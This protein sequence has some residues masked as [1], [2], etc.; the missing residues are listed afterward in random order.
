MRDIVIERHKALIEIWR[1][2]FNRVPNIY[3]HM[4]TSPAPRFFVSATTAALQCSKLQRGILKNNNPQR[5]ELYSEI[6]KRFN[7][8][9][10]QG[11]NRPAISLYEDIVFEPA[12]SFYLE[13]ATIKT[14][15]EKSQRYEY[16]R[17][18]NRRP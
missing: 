3:K 1:R 13:E 18:R 8:L 6:L 10:R 2:D 9:R 12:P 15:I 5:I 11:D 4:A 17:N 16:N 14:I 7:A